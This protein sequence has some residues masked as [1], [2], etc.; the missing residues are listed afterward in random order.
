[1][2][3]KCVESRRVIS[4]V[5]SPG[6]ADAG[7][8]G[9]AGFVITDEQIARHTREHSRCHECNRYFTPVKR[10]FFQ[11]TPMLMHQS[12]FKHILIILIIFF[13]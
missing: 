4:G 12:F 5:A 11:H 3:V 7:T 9:I 6:V 2:I 1:M 8:I 13:E 10:R